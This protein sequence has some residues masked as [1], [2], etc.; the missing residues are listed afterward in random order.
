MK[1]QEDVKCLVEDLER[2]RLIEAITD[3][4]SLRRPM[5]YDVYDLCHYYHQNK[6]T[7]FNITMLKNLCSHLEVS[8]KSKD[9]KRILIEK[10]K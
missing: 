4:I 2:E 8:F 10:I 9:K 6:L 7:T 3:E 1:Q 5:T